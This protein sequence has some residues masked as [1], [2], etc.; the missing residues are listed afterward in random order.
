VGMPRSEPVDGG[1][2]PGGA[3]IIV[4]A[5]ALLAKGM[6][7]NTSIPCN[8]VNSVGGHNFRNVPQAKPEP[9][10]TFAADFAKSCATALAGLSQRLST[11]ELNQAAAGFGFGRTWQ[12]PLSGFSG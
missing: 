4:L 5:E 7:V 9:G 12:L 10:A 2:R 8:P 11:A 6:A 3:F 1:Y